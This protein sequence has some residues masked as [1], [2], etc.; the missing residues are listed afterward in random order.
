MR[1]NMKEE[2]KPIVFTNIPIKDKDKD[3]LGI[4]NEA[5]RIENAIDE[6]ANIIGIIGDYGTGKSS[7]I[8]ML[9]NKFLNV[10]NINMW[11]SV[12]T[13]TENALVL[14]KNFIFQ[15]AIGKNEQFAQYI[16]KKMSKNF[17]VLS[18]SISTLRYWKS[19]LATVLSYFLY[20]VFS[21]LPT[22]I[23]DTGLYK[24]LSNNGIVDLIKSEYITNTIKF[25]YALCI[26]FRYLFLLISF[27]F[28][29]RI[30]YKN[31]MAVISTGATKGEKKEDCNDIYGVYLEVANEICNKKIKNK[32][33]NKREDKVL[34][35]IEDLDRINNKEDVKNFIREIYKF[36]NV[37]PEKLKEKIVY[38]IAIK[39]EESLQ[40][41]K[42]GEKNEKIFS[43][44][45]SYKTIL[46]PIHQ[47]DYNKVLL[48]LLKQKKNDIEKTFNIK[49][50]EE[51]PKEFFY[52]TKGRNLTIR[53]IKDRLNRS[54][55]LYENLLAKS[56]E[57]ENSI[58]Y[59]KCAVVA[60]LESEYPIEMKKFISE[61]KEFSDIIN[62]SYA[63]R[64]DTKL[65][66]SE[67]V[68]NIIKLID[69]KEN[70]EFI[71]EISNFIANG[72]IDDDFRMYFYNY[73]KGQ[74]IKTMS[75]KYVEDLLL[76]PDDQIEINEEMI[77]NALEIDPNIVKK[78]YVRRKN[79]KFLLPNNIFKSEILFKIALKQ[80]E[81]DLLELMQKEIKWKIESISESSKIL[82][83][84]C[85]FNC[86]LTGI[87][88]QYSEKLYIEIQQ[89]TE[90]DIEKARIEIIKTSG[91]YIK[92]FKPIFKNEKMPLITK[93]ELEIIK[94]IIVSTFPNLDK[95]KNKRK[96]TN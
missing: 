95:I 81:D 44:I 68:S 3:L 90:N 74:K 80:F 49:L 29:T 57:S 7:L 13:K 15:M 24:T 79:E 53:E 47:N 87:L 9:K 32:D 36:N 31:V 61:D 5:N 26:D 88:E 33:K 39:S 76:Y 83:N 94:D 91:K 86:D 58:E 19:T 67:K 37:L 34:I 12:N 1:L 22:N 84:I 51:L 56:D 60:Y 92:C 50:K 70:V 20:K 48:E 27:A 69:N 35:I 16:N 45:F 43:K 28:L 72:L 46:N 40:E 11:N 93:N 52:I 75:E 23:Y 85:K 21:N 17:N 82:E 8:E 14:T 30:L 6:G 41:L 78:C 96:T 25:I 73:P 63:I 71:K 54:L 62:K 64:Q 55:E 42:T 18:V 59:I 38:I 10:I 2:R 65:A 4:N 89:L 66:E 77:S